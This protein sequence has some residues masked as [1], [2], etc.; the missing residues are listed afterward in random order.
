[1]PCTLHRAPFT[2][3]LTPCIYLHFPRLH[4]F[5]AKIFPQN[6]SHVRLRQI[7]SE[8]DLC[9]KF[10]G[11]KLFFAEFDD[12]LTRSRFSVFQDNKD[13]DGFSTLVL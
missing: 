4:L 3:N 7:C 11:G 2:L 10:V 5:N 9:G 12:F 13:F 1:M 6:L 8:F